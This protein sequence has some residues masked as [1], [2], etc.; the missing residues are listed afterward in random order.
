MNVTSITN[1]APH[2]HAPAGPN[3]AVPPNEQQRSLIRAVAAVNAAD[4]FG[5]DNEVTYQV[6]RKAHQI[7]VRVV[8]RKSGQLVNQIPAEYLLRMA[9]KVNGG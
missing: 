4:A 9:E 5:P 7:V 2:V 3:P 1:T 8:N 6:D